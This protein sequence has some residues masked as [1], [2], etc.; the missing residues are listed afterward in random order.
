MSSWMQIKCKALL[1]EIDEKKKLFFAR[2]VRKTSD[3][4]KRKV[5]NI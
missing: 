5:S 1:R 2:D 4:E 3:A